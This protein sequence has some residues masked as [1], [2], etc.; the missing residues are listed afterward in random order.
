M[1]TSISVEEVSKHNSLEDLWIVIDDL[2]YDL[3]EFAPE[4][5]GGVESMFSVP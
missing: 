5:P 2:V 3:T 1:T 4:H